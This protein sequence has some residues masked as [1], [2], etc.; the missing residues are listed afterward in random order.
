MLEKFGFKKFE[1]DNSGVEISGVEISCNLF[2]LNARSP[3]HSHN[4]NCKLLFG[5][6]IR[7]QAVEIMYFVWQYGLWSFQ[8]GDTKL[9]RFLYKNPKE[10]IEF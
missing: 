5:H 10:I 8:T 1:L 4:H 9:E 7:N 3:H 6:H 2:Q